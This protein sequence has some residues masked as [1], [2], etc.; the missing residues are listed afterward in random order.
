MNESKRPT[1]TYREEIRFI[2]VVVAKR[3]HLFRTLILGFSL[4]VH[5]GFFCSFSA[6]PLPLPHSFQ[7]SF[8]SERK[9][10]CNAHN[11]KSDLRIDEKQEIEFLGRRIVVCVCERERENTSRSPARSIIR[12]LPLNFVER[13]VRPNKM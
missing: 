2:R 6:V 13:I 12:I 10:E 7:S 8:D 11:R 9:S 1:E 3:A 4:C 5:S